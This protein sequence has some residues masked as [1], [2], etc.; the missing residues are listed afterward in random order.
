MVLELFFLE[1]VGLVHISGLTCLWRYFKKTI[2]HREEE[3]VK[4]IVTMLWYNL[5]VLILLLQKV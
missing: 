3:C 2:E 5:H 4:R 1:K